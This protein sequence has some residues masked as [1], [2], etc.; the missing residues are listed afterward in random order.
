MINGKNFEEKKRLIKGR[1][2][3]KIIKVAEKKK[4]KKRKKLKK[5]QEKQFFDIIKIN[6]CYIQSSFQMNQKILSKNAAAIQ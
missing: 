6:S 5:R 1:K 2:R 4:K 3:E